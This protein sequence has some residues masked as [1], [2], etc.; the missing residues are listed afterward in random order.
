MKTSN[1]GLNSQKWVYVVFIIFAL[2][3]IVVTAQQS[4]V[5][6]KE[7]KIQAVSFE[8]AILPGS[9]RTWIKIVATFQ[10]LPRWCDGVAF[11][12]AV[13]LGA[14]NQFRVLPGTVRYANVKGGT[15]RAV[16]YIS[17]NTVERFGAPLAAHVKAFYKDELADDVALKPQSN[18]PSTWEA[19]Y[20]KYNGLLLTVIHT[21]W[22]IS[23]YSNSPD[24]FAP[25]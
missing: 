16:M 6:P 15:N 18:V 22:V 23:D 19:Q 13:L 4:S 14:E 7:V 12:Y 20:A 3:P 21:P 10:T 8:A 17:P 2:H 9:N 24:I 5:T 11:S 1:F 25:Q